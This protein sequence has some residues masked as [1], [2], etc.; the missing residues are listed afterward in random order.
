LFKKMA[1]RTKVLLGVLAGMIIV[2]AGT[3]VWGY[4]TG[5]LTSSAS[6][7][8]QYLPSVHSIPRATGIFGNLSGTVKDKDTGKA[9][10]GAT[11]AIASTND[12]TVARISLTGT[13]TSVTTDSTGVYHLTKENSSHDIKIR[14]ETSTS[15]PGIG[16]SYT[17]VYQFTISAAGYE[18]LV[19]PGV[20]WGS[21][22]SQG[23]T[24]PNKDFLLSKTTGTHKACSG[25]KC[26]DV[27]G[28]GANQCNTD[29]D[30]ATK[31][32]FLAAIYVS[33]GSTGAGQASA[34]EDPQADCTVT[35]TTDKGTKTWSHVSGDKNQ[36]TPNFLSLWELNQG[37][38]TLNSGTLVAGNGTTYKL[39]AY[40]TTQPR[41]GTTVSWISI[42]K[43]FTILAGKTVTWYLKFVQI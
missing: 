36:G 3:L 1:K 13:K 29:A 6:V 23:A 2:A 22:Y 21:Q 27:S 42:P 32:G 43:T 39:V 26:V 9:I 34:C 4:S 20:S 30:C 24:L 12:R 11:V 18:T 14:T 40:T 8:S 41:Q 33:A 35:L 37:Q 19:V 16:T 15:L 17:Y 25:T 7:L 38:Y 28:A 31:Q 5:A 10:S